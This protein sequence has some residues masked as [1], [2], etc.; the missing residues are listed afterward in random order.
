MTLVITVTET[1]LYVKDIVKWFH[2]SDK[3]LF[4]HGVEN[5]ESILVCD[6]AMTA[7]DRQAERIRV[8]TLFMP[9]SKGHKS[10][11]TWVFRSNIPAK[12][13]FYCIMRTSIIA[14]SMFSRGDF[15]SHILMINLCLVLYVANIAYLP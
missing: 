7:R 3:A 8:H 5:Q 14:F 6:L 15:L 12:R 1:K 10:I 11:N 2:L 13:L 9:Y 4:H